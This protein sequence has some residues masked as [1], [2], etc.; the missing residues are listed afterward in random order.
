[1]ADLAKLVGG[2]TALLVFAILFFSFEGNPAS[3][4]GLFFLTLYW[5]TTCVVVGF[6]LL[7]L[8][9]ARALTRRYFVKPS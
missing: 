3:A 8:S 9:T 4:Y 7:A 5:L 2:G 6:A 1:L